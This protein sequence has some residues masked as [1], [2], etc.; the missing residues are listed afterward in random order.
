MSIISELAPIDRTSV[1]VGCIACFTGMI[2]ALRKTTWTRRGGFWRDTLRPFLQ[3][4][5]LFGIGAAI[6]CI[7]RAGSFTHHTYDSDRRWVELQG[8]CD[9]GFAFAITGL[10]LC[11]VALVTVT[12]LTGRKRR[13][14]PSFVLDSPAGDGGPETAL[15]EPEVSRADEPSE[16]PPAASPQPS[17]SGTG[18]L[19]GH[20]GVSILV[21]GILGIT[22]FPVLG[23]IAWVMANHDIPEMRAGRMDPSGLG[24]T[25]AGRVC[26]IIGVV[27]LC[28]LVV[29]A[30]L[31]LFMMAI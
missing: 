14:H 25:A 26:G 6:T 4:A 22:V 31:A 20:R 1:I 16:E 12:L 23:I 3:T 11:S 10:V 8:M 7:A 21:L 15:E 2:F 17:G 24:I 30:F 18:A 27:E 28:L 29:G 19:P 13:V 9:E 5:F